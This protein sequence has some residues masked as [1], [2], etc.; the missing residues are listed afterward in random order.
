MVEAGDTV[1][2]GDAVQAGDVVEAGDA[3][4]VDNAVEAGNVMET[5]NV[6]DFWWWTLLAANQLLCS[7]PLILCL[8]PKCA[9]DNPAFCQ[10][11][12]KAQLG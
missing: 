3:V 9:Q 12:A 4:E 2:A 10:F 5:G 7:H 11:Y 6:K 1:E 8:H